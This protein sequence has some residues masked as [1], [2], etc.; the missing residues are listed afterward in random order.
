MKTS[1]L[2]VV[3]LCLLLA[4]YSFAQVPASQDTIVI[5]GGQA[6]IGDLYS[7]NNEGMTYCK[8]LV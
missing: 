3:S 6:N 2:I 1:F 7:A 4:T 8:T 5:E